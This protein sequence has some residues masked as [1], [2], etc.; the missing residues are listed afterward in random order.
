M[1]KYKIIKTQ[2]GKFEVKTRD[3]CWQ[4][5]APVKTPEGEP[6]V[7]ETIEEALRSVGFAWWNEF[8]IRVDSIGV[9]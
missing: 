9:F 5:W 6:I 4:K 3:Y 8:E 1:D 7:K 2:D